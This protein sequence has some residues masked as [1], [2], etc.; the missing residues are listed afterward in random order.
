MYHRLNHQFGR[1][2]TAGFSMS[3]LACAINSAFAAEVTDLGSVV[4]QGSNAAADVAPTRTS[5]DA[6]QPQSIIS[7]EYI[8]NSASPVS[9]YSAIAAIAPSVSL[10]ISTNG[11][12]LGE[13]KNGIRGFKDGEFN[14]TFDGIPFGDTNGVSHHSTAYFPASVIGEVVVERGP[15]NA[16]NIGAA[17]FGGSI[18]LFSRPVASEASIAPYFS[19]GS[20]NTK[21]YG[22]RYDSGILKDA[23]DM[24]VAGSY[25]K[26]TSD[27]YQT[28][29]GIQGEN[30]MLKVEK[31]L[32]QSTL[33][34]ANVNYNKNWYY[35]SDVIKG[36][37]AAEANQYGKN[38]MLGSDPTKA[39]YFGYNKTDKSTWM[40]YLRVQ[41]DLGDGWFIDNNFYHDS[42]TNHTLT[43]S[44]SDVLTGL[45]I[46]TLANGTKTGSTEMPGYRKLMEYAM[47]G[48]ILKATKQTSAGLARVG[49]WVEKMKGSRNTYNYD[50]LTGANNYDQGAVA[51]TYLTTR[52]NV[53]YDQS[54][55]WL[56]YQPFAEFE[57]AVNDKLVVTPGIKYVH[58]SLKMDALVNQ[59][60][61]LN[62]NIS[63]DF[64]AT[65]PFLTANYKLSTDWAAYAQYAQ[66][67]LV[68]NITSYYTSGANTTSISPQR[69]TN[70]Q[71]G[72]IH[73]TSQIV[74]DTDIYYINFD[75]KIAT[76]PGTTGNNAVFF[77]QG[78]VVYKGAEAALTYSFDTGL[79]TYTNFSLNRATS[80]T[81][82]LTIAGVPNNTGAIGLLYKQSGWSASLIDKLV[83]STYALEGAYKV[84]AYSS[85]DL[86][87]GYTFKNPGLGA[88]NLKASLGVYNV[89]NHQ[90]ILSATPSVKAGAAGYG[91]FNAAD[92]FTYQPERS[93]MVSVKADF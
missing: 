33:V 84:N 39:N 30:F 48:D 3:V 73:K 59:G 75:N 4:A 71:V 43:S 62:Q 23:G 36:L 41:S 55:S 78:G 38:F 17:T 6:T 22:V 89:L 79:S 82:G 46:V 61:R 20:W 24:K 31:N 11:P 85:L 80:K 93:F 18:N 77:N 5:L 26:Q 57:W 29:A 76:V 15:G 56:Q 54:L 92:T 72:A 45:G 86:N 88:K 35:Q 87:A 9:D 68:P 69:S 70:Y 21:L 52:N 2:L 83:G 25:Q 51:G 81:T 27:G 37:T 47:T 60:D 42:Y 58:H 40:N 7:R 90:D 32:G 66:G 34:T 67:M 28:Y 53:V 14:I 50:L 74:F 65:L 13:T 12:G 49:F 63:K 8:E 91:A 44:G 64:Q 10:G 16:S 19:V 1:A